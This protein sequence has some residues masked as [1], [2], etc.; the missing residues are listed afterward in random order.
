MN[1]KKINFT[2]CLAILS[3]GTFAQNND[4]VKTSMRPN[5]LK[6]TFQS[7]KFYEFAYANVNPKKVESLREYIKRVIPLA[8]MYGGK[9]FAS[10][11]VVRSESDK[12]QVNTVAIFE[13]DSPQSRLNLLEDKDYLKIKYL[14]DIAIQTEMQ[15]GWFRVNADTPIEFNPQKIYEIG[16]ANLVKD[17]GKTLQ[18]YN[19]IAEPIKRSYG[20]DY[21]EFKIVFQSIEDSKGQATFSPHMQFIVEW[22]SLED[23]DKLFANEEFKTKAVPVLMKAIDTFEPVFTKVDIQ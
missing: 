4:E 7:D 5:S 11:S 18:V 2:L 16:T 8:A 1:L 10:F 21:P 12:F 20:G 15:F 9:P 6:V 19:Q 22:R 3:I 14:R 23:K 17:G 13:W